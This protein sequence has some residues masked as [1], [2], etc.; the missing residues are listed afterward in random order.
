LGSYN[1]KVTAI[2]VLIMGKKIPNEKCVG[3]KFEE[4]TEKIMIL[5]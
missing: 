1:T 4:I 2:C 3:L 5:F